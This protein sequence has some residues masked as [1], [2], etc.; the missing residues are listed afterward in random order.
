DDQQTFYATADVFTE[1]HKKRIQR[2]FALNGF[3]Q[4][5]QTPGA[6]GSLTRVVGRDD[7]Y[8]NVPVHQVV[9]EAIQYPPA[10]DVGQIYVQGDGG[11]II[12]RGKRQGGCAH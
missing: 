3:R 9:F 5:R 7:T 2:V 8:R 6:D 4:K 1:M 12:L 10:I 11:W